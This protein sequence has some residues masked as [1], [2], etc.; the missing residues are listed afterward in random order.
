MDTTRVSAMTE[1]A[2]VQPGQREATDSVPRRFVVERMSV[3]T[4]LSALRRILTQNGPRPGMA[5]ADGDPA[6]DLP[7]VRHVPNELH[8]DL[9]LIFR[10]AKNTAESLS[11]GPT[12]WD[13]DA[14][15][16]LERLC[17]DHFTSAKVFYHKRWEDGV[18][19]AFRQYC[20]ER[21]VSTRD[22][23][24]QLIVVALLHIVDDSGGAGDLGDPDV[25]FGDLT[26]DGEALAHVRGIVRREVEACLFWR[27]SASKT[28]VCLT[29]DGELPDVEE[30]SWRELEARDC[31]RRLAKNHP[32][33]FSLLVAYEDTD[34][35]AEKEAMAAARGISYGRLRSRVS[36]A[37]K[38]AVRVASD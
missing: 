13:A 9:Y 19:A 12:R 22:G 17:S 15:A 33:E 16:A 35:R 10:A 20:A 4:L 25:P 32:E 24:R 23:W 2:E 11:A 8:H 30:S 34:S 28:H 31:R 14:E 29:D 26:P 36:E 5:N 21:G 18:G 1:V 7:D 6:S 3:S 38:T 37:R 27:P